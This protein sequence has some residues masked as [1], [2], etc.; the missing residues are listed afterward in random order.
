MPNRKGKQHMPAPEPDGPPAAHAGLIEKVAL[1]YHKALKSAQKA[2]VW[3]KRHEL[4]D[5]DLATHFQLGVANGRLLKTLPDAGEPRTSLQTLGI[6]TA[7]GNEFFND[8]MVVPLLDGDGGIIGMGGCSMAGREDRLLQT[9][10]TA[11]WNAPVAKLYAELLL[12]TSLP[13]GLSL[14]KAGFPHACALIGSH[15]KP[16][17]LTLLHDAGVRRIILFGAPKAARIVLEQL[18]GFNVRLYSLAVNDCMV[19]KGASQ[20]VAEIDRLSATVAAGGGD[21]HV[22]PQAE[23]FAVSFGRRRYE[24][25]SIDR[26]ARRLKITLKTERFGKLHVDT[27]DLYQ[28]RS[29]KTLLQD[30]CCF[31]EESPPLID[32]DIVKLIR[33]C[34]EYAPGKINEASAAPHTMTPQERQEAE[35]FG[36]QANIFDLILQDYAACGL[37]GEEPNKLLCYLAAVSRKTNDPL[38]VLILASSGAGKSTLQDATLLFCPPEDVIK[39]TSLT[40]RALFYKGAKSLK[41]KILALEEEAGAQQAAYAIRNLISA[42]ELI[43]ETTVKDLGSGRMTTMQNRVEGP[44]AVFITTTNPDTDPE[45]RSRFFVTGVDESREQTRAILETQRKRQT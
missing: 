2:R 39:L 21:G 36:Q 17:D 12:A 35:A 13:D 40:G 22:E 11:L 31:F 6:L 45:T 26:Q 27:L 38:S 15:L 14:H 42:G 7:D 5:T 23:G 20:L 9:S 1:F 28:A 3:L 10:P 30:L 8:N 16:A 33:L 18:A 41:H 43:I 44:T 19:T 32:A 4:D 24:V 34:E 25:R 29:R 37:V